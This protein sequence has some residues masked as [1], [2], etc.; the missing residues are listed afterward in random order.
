M[1]GS[2]DGTGDAPLI[3]YPCDWE[4]RVV[5][6]HEGATVAAVTEIV[7]GHDEDFDPDSIRIVPSRAGRWMSVR[8]TFTARDE[9]HVRTLVEALAA[10]PAVRMIL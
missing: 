8:L 2:D 6:A 1:A 10:H 3:E 9:R 5:A 4:L 7:A